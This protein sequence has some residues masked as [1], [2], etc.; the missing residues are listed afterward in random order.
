VLHEDLME[1]GKPERGTKRRLVRF[2]LN[3]ST[4]SWGSGAPPPETIGWREFWPMLEE[5]GRDGWPQLI[6]LPARMAHPD[7]YLT[8]DFV[9]GRLREAA[10]DQWDDQ[11]LVT[12]EPY[13]SGNYRI[14]P[15]PGDNLGGSPAG[16]ADQIDDH[17]QI[18]FLD[19]RALFRAR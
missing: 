7:P 3:H 19:A 6:R 10:T 5:C 4:V 12:L 17:R 11:D 14:A 18:V 15:A 13:E 8:S 2:D 9:A 16:Q 1:H